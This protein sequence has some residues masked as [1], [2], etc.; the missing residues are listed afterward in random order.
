MTILK[1]V[2]SISPNRLATYRERLTL[3]SDGDCLGLYIW[4]K[5]LCGVFLPVLQLLEVS[6]R[7]AIHLGYLEH[8]TRSLQADG[9][10]D[11]EI[12]TMIDRAWFKTFFESRKGQYEESWRQIESA[13]QKLATMGRPGD[14]DQIIAKL[15]YGFWSHLCSEDHDECNADSLQLWPKIQAEVF[16]GAVRNGAYISMAEIRQLLVQINHMRNRIAH[17]E[18]IWHSKQVYELPGF[19]NKLL[20]DFSKCLQV[21][22]WINP[23]NLKTLTLMQSAQEFGALC[24][25]ETIEDYRQKG[26]TLEDAAALDPHVWE[27]ACRV[28]DRH[29][30][31]VIKEGNITVIKSLNNKKTFVLDTRGKLASQANL[32]LKRNE[33]VHFVPARGQTG[34]KEILLARSVQRGHLL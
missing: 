9:K 24:M 7:N 12:A 22:V 32:N 29:N 13:E 1:A 14:I 31:V 28:Q 4:N 34:N 25:L 23:S 15:S 6:L 5:K 17:H 16:P 30:G 2:K 18:P 19:V 11:V 10:L 26:N 3:Q 21:I 27:A 8:Q 33:D 20:Q